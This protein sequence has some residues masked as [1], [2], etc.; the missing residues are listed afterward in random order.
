MGKGKVW[1][2]GAG[3]GDPGL[4]TLR[5][6]QVLQE[7]DVILYDRLV[8]EDVLK[9]AN[10]VAERIYVGK[11]AG[12]QHRRQEEILRLMLGLVQEGRNVVRLKGG[13]PMIFGRG[14]E[15]WRFLVE[16]GVPV[17]VVPGVSS[18]IALPA[19]AGIPLTYRGY[20]AGF[21]VVSGHC[22]DGMDQDWAR[23]ARV[24]TLVVLMGVKNREGIADALI[25]L[26]RDPSEPVC[27]IE[28]GSTPEERVI[29][30]T[31]GNVACGD[32]DVNP[33]AVWVIGKVVALRRV[34]FPVKEGCY[35][36]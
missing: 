7:A 28:R 16:R 4:V 14:G 34:L 27:F 19:M 25:R 21:A 6:F 36:R 29:E 23:Y 33:P 12:E 35:A 31:L 15:E 3:P 8:S 26:G 1:L 13:D 22:R 18:A 20:S 24:E 30:A 9:L 11:D 10:P 17:E 5:A 2:V 32:V